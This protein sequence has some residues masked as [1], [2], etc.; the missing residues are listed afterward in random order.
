MPDVKTFEQLATGHGVGVALLVIA[1]FALM[2]AVVALFRE[3]RALYGRMES[4]LKERVSALEHLLEARD[5][6]TRA[7]RR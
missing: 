6:P 7:S 5:E 4:L 1:C 2:T 3:N